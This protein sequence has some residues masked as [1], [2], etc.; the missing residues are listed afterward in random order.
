M[1]D[2][3]GWGETDLAAKYIKDKANA[4]QYLQCCQSRGS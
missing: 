2:A 1:K 3:Y 4:V